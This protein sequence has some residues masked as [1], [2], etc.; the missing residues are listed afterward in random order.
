V[1]RMSVL[2]AGFPQEVAGCSVNRLCGSG[3]EAVASAARAVL[4]GEAHVY[5]GGGVESMSRAPWAMPKPE[6]GLPRGNV[7]V[8]DTALGW[9]FTNRR[10][11]A[12][13]HTDSLG[14]MAENLAVELRIPRDAQDRFARSCTAWSAPASMS[15][16]RRCASAWDR[17][18]R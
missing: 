12:L 8:F 4:A 5:V 10:L 15:G 9:R 11:E 18:S 16:S 3:L 13:G 14:Q 1:E 6:K 2:L 7:T 17:A